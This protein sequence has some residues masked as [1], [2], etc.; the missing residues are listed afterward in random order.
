MRTQLRGLTWVA[1]IIINHTFFLGCQSFQ[2]TA[3]IISSSRI[4]PSRT[5]LSIA[6]PSVYD[7]EYEEAEKSRKVA[8]EKRRQ[9]LLKSHGAS[10]RDDPE[11]KFFDTARLHVSGGDGGNGCVAFRREK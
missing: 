1:I 3:P 4:I 11:W 7:A 8:S 5:S 2:T 10:E 9:K 6:E